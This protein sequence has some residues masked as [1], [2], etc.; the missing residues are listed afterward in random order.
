MNLLKKKPSKI[1]LVGLNYSDHA[2]ELGYA[3]PGEPVIFLKPPSSVIGNGDVIRY[4]SLVDRI[5]YEA[6]LAF[7][8]KKEAGNVKERDAH[9]YIL[10]YTCLNDVTAR[11]LQKKDG[12][13]T[14][15]KSFDTFCPIGP[16]IETSLGIEEAEDLSIRCLVNGMVKQDSSTR[17]FIFGI[18][19]LLSFI[20][21][22]MTLYPFDVISTGTPPGVGPLAVGDTVQVEIEKVGV[23]TNRVTRSSVRGER[24]AG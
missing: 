12:Q 20:S 15:S 3:I 22:C 2:G 10:G 24:S 4:P 16:G 8:I 19:K 13:W 1:V 7:V 9:Q 23:L 18:R 14:R 17:H 11:N 21:S 6:E 5:D